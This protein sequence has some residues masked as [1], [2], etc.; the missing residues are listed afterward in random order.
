NIDELPL[1]DPLDDDS[2]EHFRRRFYF[3]TFNGVPGGD[4]PRQFDERYYALRTAVQSSVSSP[5]TEIADDLTMA[6]LGI[7]QRWQTKR[8][9]PGRERIIDWITLDVQGSFFPEAQ[10]DDFGQDWGLVNYD[11]SWH[12]G[13]RL[14]LLSDG[15]ADFF[16]D[17]LQTVSVGAVSS[18]P[19]IGSLYV[20]YRQI[21]GAFQGQIVN[22][23]LTYRMS[24]KWML[25]AGSSFDLGNA[26][27]IGQ[28]VNVTRIG[29]SF[30]IRV[31]LNYD[32]SRDNVNFQ[33][34]IQPRFL[35]SGLMGRGVQFPPVGAMG[36]E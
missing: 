19:G 17:G 6:R 9:L 28:T 26:G 8:G 30:L 25:G 12:V 18:R 16:P 31:G 21:E 4:V 15:Y 33:F 24:E 35:T 13:D 22:A 29:E 14:T 36:L 2:I 5:T 20:G 23:F 7:H 10:R 1:Y 27:N 3:N 32:E 11:F 34:D